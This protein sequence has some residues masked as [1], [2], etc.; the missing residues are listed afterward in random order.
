MARLISFP[1]DV[2]HKEWKDDIREWPQEEHV[3]TII[4]FGVEIFKEIMHFHYM[5][6]MATP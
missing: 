6:Y 2:Q 5:T 3:D 4:L 1:K